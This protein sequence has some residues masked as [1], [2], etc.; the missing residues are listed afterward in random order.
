MMLTPGEMAEVDQAHQAFL[1][2]M[3]A[4]WRRIYDALLAQEFT[5]EQAFD[6]LKLYVQGPPA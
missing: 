1:N 3:P 6:L 2:V 4:F 5:K